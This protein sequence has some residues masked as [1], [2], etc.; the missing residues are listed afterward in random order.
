M[1]DRAEGI[2][3]SAALQPRDAGEMYVW[4]GDDT[5]R[6]TGDATAVWS[7][8]NPATQAMSCPNVVEPRRIDVLYHFPSLSA[9]YQMVRRIRTC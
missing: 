7:G 6:P 4:G 1:S 3:I 2:G 9:R 8:W 5:C